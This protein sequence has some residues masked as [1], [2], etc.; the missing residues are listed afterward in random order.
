MSKKPGN[1]L[2]KPDEATLQQAVPMRPVSPFD[3]ME[4]R[5]ARLF[6]GF[7]PRNWM[8]PV[9]WEHPMLHDFPRFEMKAPNVDIIDRDNDIVLKAEIPGVDKADLE[10]SV[11]ETSVTISGKTSHEEKEAKGNYYRSEIRYGSFIRTVA[12]PRAVDGTKAL[13]SFKNGILELTLPKLEK[14]KRVSV[15]VQ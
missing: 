4:E 2:K 5:M 14:S 13:A 3:E 10:V 7:F 11:D 9:H 12:L 8:R 6:E 15:K 1:E